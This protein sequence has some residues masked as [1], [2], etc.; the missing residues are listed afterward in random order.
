MV[1]RRSSSVWR[2]YASDGLP[3]LEKMPYFHF[4]PTVVI[5]A[6]FLVTFIE[7]AN[8]SNIV[9]AVFFS[10]ENLLKRVADCAVSIFS[11]PTSGFAQLMYII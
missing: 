11:L 2:V 4:L 3:Q 9:E 8:P 5:G 1:Y 10:K 7:E 6:R